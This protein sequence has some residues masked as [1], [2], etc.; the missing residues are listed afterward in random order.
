MTALADD[1]KFTTDYPWHHGAS[2]RSRGVRVFGIS[3]ALLALSACTTYGNVENKPLAPS[4]DVAQNYSVKAHGQS[5]P[6]GDVLLLLAFSGGG[7]RAAALTY[8]VMQELRDTAVP[9][10]RLLDEV[11]TISSVSGGSFT[12]AYYG[13]HGDRLFTD[14]EDV[15]LKRD[16]E[17]HLF[18]QL[19]N[20][21]N[22]L[23]SEGRTERAVDYYENNIFHGATFADMA[24]ADGPLILINTSDLGSGARFSFV[25]EYFKLLCS[26]ISSFSIARAVTASSAVPVVFN[27]IVVENFAECGSTVPDWLVAA[28]KR[29]AGDPEMAMVVAGVES[30]FD[31]EERKYAHFVDGGITDN[32]GLR[33]IYEVVEL[34]GG[35]MTTLRKYRHGNVPRRIVLVSVDASTDGNKKMDLSNAE[36]GIF[37]SIGAM[38]DVQLHRYNVDTNQLI[39]K[40]LERWRQELSTPARPV[41]AY[42]VRLGF[43]QIADAK[44]R[45]FLNSVPTSFKL[46][47]EQVARVSAAGRQLLREN[48][49]FQRLLKSLAG[50]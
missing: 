29:A 33:A 49:D 4:D 18:A 23:S 39:L 32:L 2:A 13:L 12:A 43:K 5:H 15:F 38:S 11:D 7:T 28:R 48:A 6:A 44:E 34:S 45:K 9:S 22:W 21:L 3:V 20:P 14:F 35:A 10:G 25:Q 19:F 8:G 26:D 1:A 40:T 41:E 46:S 16:V 42:F 17:G 36:P 37:D 31:K 27:P 50:G 47:E 30:Y 24:A